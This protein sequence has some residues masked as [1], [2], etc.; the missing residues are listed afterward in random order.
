M[1]CGTQ[2]TAFIY[3]ALE[4]FPHNGEVIDKFGEFNAGYMSGWMVSLNDWFINMG[5]SEF[6]VTEGDTIT[7]QYTSDIGE[8]IGSDWM[9]TSAKFMGLI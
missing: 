2:K 7:W 6:L 4:N 1:Y 5:A 9:N 3:S 8:D